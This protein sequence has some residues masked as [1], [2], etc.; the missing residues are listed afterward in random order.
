MY[1]DDK[2][3]NI[4]NADKESVKSCCLIKSDIGMAALICKYCNP[5]IP[6]GYKFEQ[7][8]GVLFLRL[9]IESVRT[10]FLS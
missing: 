10:L 4:K 8:S 1:R 3:I 5:F 9:P 6:I 2:A 7:Y